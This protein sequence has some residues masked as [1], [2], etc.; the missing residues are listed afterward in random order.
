MGSTMSET[1]AFPTSDAASEGQTSNLRV[2]PHAIEAEQ[3]VIGGL[4]LDNR[5]W[6]QI[7][8]KLVDEDFYRFDH[9]LL[10]SA[11]RELESRNEPF[12]AVTLSQCL[13]KNGQLE[14]AGGLLYLGRLAKDTPSA[15]NILAYANIVREKSV[16]RQLIAVGTDISGSGYIPEGRDSKELLDDAEKKVFQIAEQ[17][18]RGQNGF[19][20]MKTLLSKTVD[21]IDHLFNSDGGITGVSTGFDKFDE[22]TTGLQ[23]A[24]LV[25]VAGR[26]SMG[27]TTFAMNIAENAAIG[28]KLPVAVFSM[29]MPGDSL[30][31]RMISSLGRVDQH[32]IRT[33]NLTD[34]DWAR[35][36][37]AIHILSEA[38]IFI[39]DTPAMSPHEIRARARRLKRQHGLGLIVIDYL[40]LM[41]VHGGS[42]NRA[43]EISEISRSLKA[44]AKEL[45]VPVIALSQLN[46]SLESRPDKRPVMSDLR[47]SGA[48]EQDADLIVFIYRDEVY[49]EDSPQKG[50]AEIII[51][52]QRNGP[53]GKSLLTFLGKYTKFENYIPE[54]YNTDGFE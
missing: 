9:R 32:H 17:G 7:A 45:K 3:A 1:A 16:L 35:I 44:M 28:D 6:E 18:A 37:S 42:E 43:T 53:I 48:I 26:P 24:D 38:K 54:M 39:D 30:A 12:D 10:F 13:E 11:I 52:K 51:A 50:V 46:R 19:Q 5:A 23:E 41:Q 25:I 36:T 15:S 47:E 29:E 20:D 49:N 21:K 4:L 22:M 8:D 27:K 40:Q 33:G 2:P 14:Q 34:E 31:M